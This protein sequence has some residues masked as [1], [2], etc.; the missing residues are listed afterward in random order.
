M[1]QIILSSKTVI[2]FE[3][4]FTCKGGSENLRPGHRWC[5][6]TFS[7]EKFKKINETRTEKFT[8]PSRIHINTFYHLLKQHMCH[9][10]GVLSQDIHCQMKDGEYDV[11]G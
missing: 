7:L 6:T 4:L 10:E 5:K 11:S 2:E 9:P 8:C 3:F 1:L